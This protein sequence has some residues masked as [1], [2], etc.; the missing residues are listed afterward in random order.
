MTL[1]IPEIVSHTSAGMHSAILEAFPMA[2]DYSAKAYEG[3]CEG[4]RRHRDVMAAFTALR[5]IFTSVRWPCDID[6][7]LCER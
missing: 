4:K 5:L 6:Y 3:L 7:E 2:T 1:T